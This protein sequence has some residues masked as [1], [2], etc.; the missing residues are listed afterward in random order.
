MMKLSYCPD[1]YRVRQEVI[2]NH[3]AVKHELVFIY[4]FKTLSDVM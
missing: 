1:A 4:Y 3:S 2:N